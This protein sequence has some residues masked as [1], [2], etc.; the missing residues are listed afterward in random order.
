VAYNWNFTDLDQYASLWGRGLLNTLWL[1]AGSIALG[2]VLAGA[3]YTV[4]RSRI[5][6]IRGV[7]VA[8][9]DVFRALPVFVLLSLIFFVLPILTGW[10]ISA[11][12]CAFLA[13]SLNLAPFVA[14]VVRG[15]IESVPLVQY[16]SGK[17][18]G[19]TDRQTFRHIIA[20]QALQRIIP[21]LL[22]EWITTIKLTSLA[23]VIGVQEIWNVGGQIVSRTSLTIEARIVAA[24]LYLLIIL[25]LIW[26]LTLLERRHGLRGVVASLSPS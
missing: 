22:G 19:L 1:S 14:E 15:G 7:A 18:L 5:T 25:P 21:P 10:R 11:W 4:R 24:G 23:S 8:Y 6:L 17:V 2:T 20:P 26:L 16:E 12:Q 3:L 13:F 9:T